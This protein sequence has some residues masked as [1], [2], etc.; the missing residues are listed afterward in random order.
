MPIRRMA[1]ECRLRRGGRRDLEACVARCGATKNRGLRLQSSGRWRFRSELGVPP[2]ER[3]FESSVQ[4]TRPHL[5]QQMRSSLGP[6]H[7]LF[8]HSIYGASP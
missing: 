1:A 4:Y 5:Q 7:L 3:F 6:R 8:F 2:A